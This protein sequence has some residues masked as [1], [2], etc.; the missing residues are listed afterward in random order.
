MK[1]FLV[2]VS[3][4]LSVVAVNCEERTTTQPPLAPSGVHQ[5]SPQGAKLVT[6][7]PDDNSDGAPTPTTTD[8]AVLRRAD[9]LLTS[10]S[11]WNHFGY[12]DCDA[13]ARAW[14]LYCVLYRASLDVIG[15]AC[16][17]SAAM[18]EV[19]WIVEDRTRGVDLA[20]RLMDYNNLPT[21]T[22]GDIKSLLQEAIRRLSRKLPTSTHPASRGGRDRDGYQG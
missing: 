5:D 6:C 9:D 16:H 15:R 10:P 18:Q 19:R 22:F 1:R 8:L 13:S 17:R 12:R 7:P 21:T 2:V 14:N 20:H 11:A 4:G 3:A